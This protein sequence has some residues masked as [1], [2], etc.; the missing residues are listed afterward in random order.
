MHI[1]QGRCEDQTSRTR[2]S[3]SSLLPLKERCP[4]VTDIVRLNVSTQHID[5]PIKQASQIK[6]GIFVTLM[7]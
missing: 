6:N 4:A 1:A 2:W 7:V 3:C 5:G